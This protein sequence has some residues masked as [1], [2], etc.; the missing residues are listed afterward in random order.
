M[1]KWFAKCCAGD[2]SLD[3]A[4]RLGGPVEVDS[5]PMETIIENNQHYPTWETADI[6]KISKSMKSW[7]KM[8]NVSFILQKKLNGHPA[9]HGTQ[10][11]VSVAR[12]PFHVAHG[13]G[14]R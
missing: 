5:D 2:S 4:P 1:S 10:T 13:P 7:V 8:K 12:S 6:L 3:D 11:H 14:P 9:Q